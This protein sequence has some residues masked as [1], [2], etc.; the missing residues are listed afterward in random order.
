M[1][2][3]FNLEGQTPWGIYKFQQVASL[4]ERQIRSG[5]ATVS[6]INGQ[7]S[8]LEA[9]IGG[10]N[11]LVEA[12]EGQYS[13]LRGVDSSIKQNTLA[14]LQNGLQLGNIAAAQQ[15]ANSLLQDINETGKEGNKLMFGIAGMIAKL[16]GDDIKEVF[17]E[18]FDKVPIPKPRTIP[19]RLKFVGLRLDTFAIAIGEYSKIFG[20]EIVV[21]GFQKYS[22]LTTDQLAQLNPQDIKDRIILDNYKRGRVMSDALDGIAS[23][24]KEELDTV[25]TTLTRTVKGSEA[26]QRLVEMR[27]SLWGT[28]SVVSPIIVDIN[29]G[30][31]AGFEKTVVAG[32]KLESPPRYRPTDRSILAICADT[33]AYTIYYPGDQTPEEV[34][35]ARALVFSGDSGQAFFNPRL[36]QVGWRDVG[37]GSN[38]HLRM[39]YSI[40]DDQFEGWVRRNTKY[41]ALP[42]NDRASSEVGIDYIERTLDW[43]RVSSAVFES[44]ELR[45][46]NK[47]LPQ[48]L[49]DKSHSRLEQDQIKKLE[50][51]ELIAANAL[52][53]EDLE[54]QIAELTREIKDPSP[55]PR[56]KSIR[57]FIYRH[58]YAK[59]QENERDREGMY[60][61]MEKL[62]GQISANHY[63]TGELSHELGYINSA[64]SDYQ[65][66]LDEFSSSNI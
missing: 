36:R 57:E 1:S 9:Q 37:R 59:Q 7:N 60:Q 4:Q 22:G 17:P 20:E 2:V 3:V 14:V 28:D 24:Y 41:L 49:L 29:Y 25:E 21:A 48:N 44:Q 32:Y 42:I 11:N 54:R 34:F 12:I 35:Q 40:F 27:D 63:K 50:I 51:P 64:V 30:N 33:P 31:V 16:S 23:G 38:R 26:K 62:R 15:E 52:A 66:A 46:S 45:V 10:I 39:N 47:R 53:N 6:A 65:R 18:Y 19:E 5:V 61:S 55:L 56:S 13:L 8:F 43:A 58:S